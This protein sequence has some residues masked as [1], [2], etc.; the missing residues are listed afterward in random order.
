MP[1]ARGKLCVAELGPDEV[2]SLTADA[3][4]HGIAYI[5]TGNPLSHPMPLAAMRHFA[6]PHERVPRLAD[7]LADLPRQNGVIIGIVDVGGF[8]FAHPDFVVNGRTR[9]LEIWDQGAQSDGSMDMFHFGRVL[10]RDAM[11]DAMQDAAAV[12]VDASDFLEQSTQRLGSHGTHVAS[13]AAGNGGVCPHAEIVGVTI[14]LDEADD[15][16]HSTFY[17]S[18]RLAQAV[19]YI[20]DIGERENLP[21]VIN[22]SLGTNGHAHDGTSPIS[23]WIDA[24]LGRPGRCVCVAAGNAG[25]EGA[26]IRRRHRLHH[27][28]YPRQRSD[29]RPRPHQGPEMA[30]RRQWCR[31]CIRERA[32]DLVPSGR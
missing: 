26:T 10:T 11:N 24:A 7:A 25:Q 12:G 20:F 22:I 17:D 28:P 18:T 32:R 16:R 27:G 2:Q 21:V 31:R 6:S 19:D 15:D 5:E 3:P 14:A 29:S 30:G 4:A 9:F 13:I 1:V 23:R 8:D